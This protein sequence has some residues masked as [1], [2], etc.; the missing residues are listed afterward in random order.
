MHWQ[1]CKLL[2]VRLV[3]YKSMYLHKLARFLLFNDDYE[4][5]GCAYHL[6]WTDSNWYTQCSWSGTLC[7]YSFW[8]YINLLIR[9][10]PLNVGI[11]THTTHI[12]HTIILK[13]I[14]RSHW[15][16]CE[17]V[18]IPTSDADASGTH[19]FLMYI[20]LVYARYTIQH[21]K[22]WWSSIDEL[23]Y[24]QIFFLFSSFIYYAI[25]G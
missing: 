2:L 25:D 5:M 13:F 14:I 24:M 7:D 1:N 6:F 17:E 10:S 4:M 8:W 19:F 16:E 23:I 22:W 15:F 3:Y 12:A 18:P 9:M 21:G 20:P 11:T